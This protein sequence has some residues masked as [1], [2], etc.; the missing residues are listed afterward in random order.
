[1]KGTALGDWTK[2][3]GY[4]PNGQKYENGSGSSYG[5]TLATGDLVGVKYDADTRQ[6]EFFKNNVSQGVAYTVSSDY[7]YYPSIHGNAID[8]T[9]N[10][11]QKP[12]RYAPPAG[13]QPL[14]AANVRPETVITRP[15]QYVDVSTWTVPSG[16]ANTTIVTPFK[17]DLVMAK[18]RSG[19]D[20]GSIYNSVSGDTKF[21]RIFDSE[22]NANDAEAT[23]ATR[24]NFNNNG[25]TFEA[26][27]DNANYGAGDNSVAWS[28]KA[29]GGKSGGGGFFK[30]DV[31]YGSANAAGLTSGSITAASV[32]TKQGFS[33]IH[34]SGGGGSS[35]SHGLSQTPGFF[36]IACR[37]VTNGNYYDAWHSGYYV[38]GS[39]NYM[40]L[41][42]AGN[43]GYASDMFGTPTSSVVTLGGSSSMNGSNNYTLYCWHDVPGLQKFGKYSGSG[44]NDGT[45]VELG[46]RPT[47]V[48]VKSDSTAGQ[49]WIVYD[50]KRTPNN[51][52]NKYLIIETNASDST[53]REI[54]FLSNGFKLRNGASGATDFSGRTYIYCAWAEAP[55][56]NLYG[57][58]SNA[59]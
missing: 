14:N 11:G 45:F 6:L 10:F 44:N 12:F 19:T 22:T 8:V 36:F 3:Y 32:G 16:N 31:E 43:A 5:A 55:V 56:S 4:S 58:Q 1:M 29:G 24:F 47:L 34:Y 51:A 25:F 59:R 49:E 9:A 28:W 42:T 57:G 30:D 48:W 53:G 54:D 33:I 40:R 13:Y 52:I 38:S 27:N 17:P 46:F 50:S 2:I 7:N 20:G 23:A 35:V 37:N 15:D 21:M 39:K 41:T 26:D 18:N